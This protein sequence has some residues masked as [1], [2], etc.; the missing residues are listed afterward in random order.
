MAFQTPITVES[1]L[2]RIT[3][4]EYVLPAIQR[5]FVWSDEQICRLFDSLMRRYPIGSFLFWKVEAAK[6]GDFAYYGFLRDFHE[7]DAHHSPQLNVPGHTGVT[8]ILDGQQRLTSLY[9]GLRG[10]HAKRVRYGWVNNPQAYPTRYL[11]LNIAQPAPENELGME[12]NFRFLTPEHGA[13]DAYGEAHW[14]KVREITKFNDASDIFDYI[15]SQDL[16][17]NKA[18]FKDAESSA[19]CRHVRAGYQL[20]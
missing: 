9:I 14:F 12:Y 19:R 11:Y 7:R 18:A 3:K 20:L 13:N 16:A 10:S 5:E 4:Q 8:A 6:V 17:T 1:A 15:Q 2:D